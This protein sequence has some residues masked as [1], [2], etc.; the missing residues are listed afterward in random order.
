MRLRSIL[1]TAVLASAA[2]LAARPLRAQAAPAD[3]A[4]HAIAPTPQPHYKLRFAA[5]F[6]S[7][8]LAH[9]SGHIIASYAVGGHPS[10]GFNRWRPTI[11]SGIDSRLDPHKQFIFSSAGLTV[12]TLLDETILDV[13]HAKGSIAGP[14]ERGLL[15]GGLGTVLFYITLGRNG[16]VSDVSF[17]SRTSSLS[18]TQI[19]FIYGSIAVMHA[20][21]IHVKDRYAHFFSAPDDTGHLRIGMSISPE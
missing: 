14:F 2:V 7:S 13:P 17:M 21:R 4:P 10:F 15:A 1:A 18:K 6:I 16:S 9:E 8:I 5:G 11:Y 19:S 3:T 20:V 12:Q